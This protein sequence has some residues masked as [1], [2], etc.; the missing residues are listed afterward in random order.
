MPWFCVRTFIRSKPTGRATSP[1]GRLIKNIAA[2]E[3]RIVLF[4]ARNADVALRKGRREAEKYAEAETVN[5]YGQ[6]VV[7]TLLRYVEAYEMFDDPGDGVEAFSSIEIVGSSETPRQI[8]K[9]RVGETSDPRTGRMFMSGKIA[10][11]LDD[12]LGRW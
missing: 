2:I 4:K 7:N 11:D 1:D 9:R 10:R 8:L 6:R 12:R 5:V 3:E